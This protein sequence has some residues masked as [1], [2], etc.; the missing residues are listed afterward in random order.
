MGR[1]VERGSCCSFRC[2]DPTFACRDWSKTRNPSLGRPATGHR[3]CNYLR[4][5]RTISQMRLCNPGQPDNDCSRCCLHL[6]F[7]VAFTLGSKCQG[8]E[9]Q[10]EFIANSISLYAFII[11][12]AYRRSWN[13]KRRRLPG[14]VIRLM[15]F[16]KL[17]DSNFHS[18]AQYLDLSDGTISSVIASSYPCLMS[19]LSYS[20]LHGDRLA[21]SN[22]QISHDILF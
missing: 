10:R 17:F 5:L 14:V 12:I 1:N 15:C 13:W 20:M 22:T 8:R 16:Q 19:V 21:L 6:V 2:S 4:Y 18:L 3:G 11:Y 9:Y 7:C